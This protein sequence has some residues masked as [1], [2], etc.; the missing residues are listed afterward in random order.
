MS[1]SASLRSGAAA[2]QA[3][4]DALAR[5]ASPVAVVTALDGG[6][7]HG[8]MVSAFAPL[9]LMPPMVLILLDQHSHLLAVIRRSG[10]FLGAHQ[11]DLASAFAPPDP[12]SSIRSL[13]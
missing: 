5:V 11:A 10:R 9:S 8:T 6:R 13:A 1:I 12:T 4:P 3:F 2:Q 7:P